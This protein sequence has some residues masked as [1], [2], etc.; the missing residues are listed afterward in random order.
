M[1]DREAWQDIL[2][3]IYDAALD[4]AL[5]TPAIGAIM[6]RIGADQASLF[7][8]IVGPTGQP[9]LLLNAQTP[10]DIWALYHSYYWQYDLSMQEVVRRGLHRSGS[11]ASIDDLVSR[12]N[13]RN[14]EFYDLL[15]LQQCDNLIGG[16]IEGFDSKEHPPMNLTFH[17]AIGSEPFGQKENRMLRD[18]L[19]HFRRALRIRWRMA[20]HE[21]A[22]SL[23]E[24]ALEHMPQ[25]V[26]LLDPAGYILYANGR[27]EALF[28]QGAGPTAI[29][30]RFT[31]AE[32]GNATRIKE[33]LGKCS[34]GEGASVKLESFASGK[35]WI[36]SFV[37]LRALAPH[38]E[39]QARV[40]LLISLPDQ[41]PTQGLPHFARLYR[42]TP[43]ETRVLQHLLERQSTQDI[44]EALK[45][46]VKTLR[47][48]LSNLFSKTGTVNQRELVRFFFSHPSAGG[49]KVE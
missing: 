39:S 46:S 5:W 28:R 43:A 10:Q 47:I 29:G 31:A 20:Q 45:I 9:P 25:A 15:R 6:D 49:V 13:L 3:G 4:D 11:I 26:A 44:A 41:A 23:R 2:G 19:P 8:P 12:K 32:A 48:H 21:D 36:A 7:S 22:R 27:A 24:A 38:N 1:N 34:A 16:V 35:S 17:R 18:L 14:G 37:P 42:L 40:L 30:R 33:A